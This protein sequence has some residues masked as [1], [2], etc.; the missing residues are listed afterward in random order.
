MR[1]RRVVLLLCYVVP[2]A[3]F[4]LDTL[5]CNRRDRIGHD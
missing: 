3:A 4:A 2:P 1:W 5:L